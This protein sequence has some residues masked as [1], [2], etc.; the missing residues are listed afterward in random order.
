MQMKTIMSSI[1]LPLAERLDALV[2]HVELSHDQVVT[3]AIAAWIDREEER[4]LMDLRMLVSANSIFVER[5]RVI[6]W[7]DSL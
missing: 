1:P 4:R 2:E 5:N 3:D 6:D 7:A